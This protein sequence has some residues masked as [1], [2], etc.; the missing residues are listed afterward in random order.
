MLTV[1]I[2]YCA[3]S[4]SISNHIYH[5]LIYWKI[6]WLILVNGCYISHWTVA[7]YHTGLLLHITLDCGSPFD[8]ILWHIV[9]YPA[10]LAI[11]TTFFSQ[12]FHINVR[13][14]ALQ[15]VVHIRVYRHI[16]AHILHIGTCLICLAYWHI[17]DH[18]LI[19]ID[20]YGCYIKCCSILSPFVQCSEDVEVW[21]NI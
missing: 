15:N 5:I 6:Y 16:S 8:S 9:T 17:S 7:T 12:L 13:Q 1:H 3:Q 21:S 4:I 10:Y 11:L 18:I 14:H 19:H 2:A 20:T